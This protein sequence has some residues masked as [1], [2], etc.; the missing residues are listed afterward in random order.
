MPVGGL[1][2]RRQKDDQRICEIVERDRRQAP[3]RGRKLRSKVNRTCGYR[4][5]LSPV[6]MKRNPMQSI[7]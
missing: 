6:S 1:A 3:K 7:G 4:V 5:C 2:N